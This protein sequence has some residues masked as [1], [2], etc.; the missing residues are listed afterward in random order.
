MLNY[1]VEGNHKMNRKLCAKLVIQLLSRS[2]RIERISHITYTDVQYCSQSYKF[3]EKYD[4]DLLEESRLPLQ[5]LCELH[6]HPA[7]F[8]P[9]SPTMMLGFKHQLLLR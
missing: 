9:M 7:Y 3:T 4:S 2:I 8:I 5:Y 6:F 1:A